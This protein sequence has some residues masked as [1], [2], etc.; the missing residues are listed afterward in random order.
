M[1]PRWRVLFVLTLAVAGVACA[2]AALPRPR[3]AA[4]HDDAG[5][6]ASDVDGAAASPVDAGL[7]VAA[8]AERLAPG[9]RELERTRIDPRDGGAY[10]LAPTDADRCYR[11]A[12]VAPE[13]ASATLTD[14]AGHVLATTRGATTAVGAKGPVCLRKGQRATLAVQGAPAGV[15]EIIVWTSP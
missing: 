9:M 3:S 5:L 14:D 7:D 12:I 11:I 6:D 8:L 15:V 10:A 2:A 4:A 1:I 13:I